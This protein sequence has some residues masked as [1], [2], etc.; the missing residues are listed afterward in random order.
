MYTH[1]HHAHTCI[2][3]IHMYI[4]ML[5][6]FY[7]LLYLLL[8]IK[9]EFTLTS[10]I[11]I[12]Y[13]SVLPY[14]LCF[15]ISNSLVSEK[16]GS[17]CPQ[18]IIC[19]TLLYVTNLPLWPPCLFPCHRHPPHPTWNLTPHPQPWQTLLLGCQGSDTLCQAGTGAVLFGYPLHPTPTLTS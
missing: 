14:F 10:L 7:F 4:H 9:N 1:T 16:L 11:Q 3:Y 17:H 5:F 15:P 6:H 12:Q 8:Y 2:M 13:H 19:L 18:Y